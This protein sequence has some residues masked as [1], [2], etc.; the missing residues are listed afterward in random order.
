MYQDKKFKLKVIGLFVAA[1]TS[2]PFVAQAQQ[3]DFKACVDTAL[4][5]NPEMEVSAARIHQAEAALQKAE[6]SRL[7]QVTVSVTGSKSDNPL[8]VF[9]MKLQQQQVALADFGVDNQMLQ[10]LN[11]GDFA[12]EPDTLNNPDSHTDFNTRIEV[13]L[14]VWNGGRIGSYEDQA[15]AM[16]EAAK[17]GDTA[18]QQYLTFNIYQAYE[19]VHAARAYINVAKQAKETADSYVD[20]TRNLVDQGIVVRSEFLSAK[21]NQSAATVALAKAEAEEKIALQTLKMLMNV[22]AKTDLDVAGRL[23]LQ[24]PVNNE[25][26]LLSL[27]LNSNPEL[28]AKRKQAEAST[29]EIKAAK[30]DYY[31]SFNMMLRNDWNDESL[32]LANS[33]YTVA[34]VLSWKITDFGVTEGS[35]NMAAAAAAQR[36][37]EARSHENNVRIQVLTAWNKLQAAEQQVLSNLLAVQQAEEARRLVVKRY[38]NGISTITEL[39]AANTQLDKARA[40][41]VT[42]RYDVNVQKAKLLLATGRMDTNRL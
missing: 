23:D 6:S 8:N 34:G 15:A 37:A 35:V 25:E 4:A 40:E 3:Y 19:A 16:I 32:A 41:L 11:T 36:K 22:D 21:V 31:P 17:N 39:L 30:A 5:Q 2:F 9:G 13:L 24:L 26:E 42:A 1:A 29:Y 18:V 14:P 7:P 12:Y 33:S 28:D 27:A 10:A 20:T 38:N